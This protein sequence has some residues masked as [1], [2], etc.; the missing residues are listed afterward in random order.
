MKRNRKIN[1]LAYKTKRNVFYLFQQ[2]DFLLERG[3]LELNWPRLREIARDKYK[4][5]IGKSLATFFRLK[6]LFKKMLL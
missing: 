1:T 3:T 2:S 6:L 4:N 5:H